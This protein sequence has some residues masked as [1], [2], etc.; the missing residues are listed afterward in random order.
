MKHTLIAFLTLASFSAIA[1][2]SETNT[3]MNADF[4]KTKPTIEQVKAEIAKG[5]S[6]S[7]PNEASWD[8]TA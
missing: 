8:P 6:P 7:Q 4:W 5:N 2:P 3:L 1:Q